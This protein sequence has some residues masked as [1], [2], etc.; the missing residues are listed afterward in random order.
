MTDSSRLAQLDLSINLVETI[1]G[2]QEN[3]M[4][5]VELLEIEFPNDHF[6]EEEIHELS[7]IAYEVAE[8]KILFEHMGMEVPN[9]D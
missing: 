8:K 9:Y 4:Q 7:Y 5:L 1:Y 2:K 6:T 3:V